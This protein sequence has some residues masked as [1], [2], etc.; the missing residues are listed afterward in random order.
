MN[1]KNKIWKEIRDNLIKRIIDWE[2]ELNSKFLSITEL[3]NE[4]QISN[5]TSRRVIAELSELGYIESIPGKGSFVRSRLEEKNIFLLSKEIIEISSRDSL[6]NLHSEIYKGMLMECGRRHADL[7]MLSIKYLKNWPEDK[8]LMLLI[9]GD[10][11]INDPDLK[12]ILR[13]PN[14]YRVFYH[15]KVPLKNEVSVRIP[16]AKGIS[17]AVEYLIEQG[18]TRIAF[19]VSSLKKGS[20]SERF[21]GYYETLKQY[22][23]P[24]DFNLVRELPPP[25][26]KS[27]SEAIKSL[28]ELD[29]PPT[30]VVTANNTRAL[31]VIEFCNSEGIKV[32]EQLA[33][34]GFDNIPESMLSSPKLTVVNTFWDKIGSESVR[35]LLEMAESN[36]KNLDDVIIDPELVIRDST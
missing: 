24:L 34:A 4:Y 6:P 35:L 18:H 22:N 33:V 20:M 16:Y 21:E 25:D 31:N 7:Q 26:I 29:T 8:R 3:S 36:N 14:C 12:K 15:S 28:L 9:S 32:P 17:L 30:A 23:I 27:D 10:E 11:V 2:F 1:K 19:L 13:R 5:I